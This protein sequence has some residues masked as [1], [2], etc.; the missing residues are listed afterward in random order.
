MGGHAGLQAVDK[1]RTANQKYS[2]GERIDEKLHI[3][4]TAM[5]IDEKL[6][7]SQLAQ[8]A[9]ATTRA[10][11]ERFSITERTCAAAEQ[12]SSFIKAED[13]KLGISDRIS[14]G[15][16]ETHTKLSSWVK[17]QVAKT[18]QSTLSSAP[19]HQKFDVNVC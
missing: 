19:T 9:E 11:N 13:E 8:Q 14:I 4:E 10:L 6:H 2:I 5:M 7:L 18:T 3:K 15:V 16:N 17:K 1:S 12:I